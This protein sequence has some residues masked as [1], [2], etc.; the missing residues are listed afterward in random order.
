MCWGVFVLAM[1][2][3]KSVNTIYA[4]RFLIGESFASIGHLSA[5]TGGR[6]LRGCGISRTARH[7]GLLVWVSFAGRCQY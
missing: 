2:G 3:A 7:S 4:M 6:F 5:L 1:A